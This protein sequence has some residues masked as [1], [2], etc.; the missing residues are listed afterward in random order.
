MVEALIRVNFS[1][2]LECRCEP[3]LCARD[4]PGASNRIALP[5]VYGRAAR[6]DERAIVMG[7]IVPKGRSQLDALRWLGRNYPEALKAYMRAG[8]DEALKIRRGTA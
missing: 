2:R 4:G 6:Q 5:R 1:G 7:T 3:V 8:R